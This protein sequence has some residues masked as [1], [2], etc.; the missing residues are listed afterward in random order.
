METCL[1]GVKG[2]HNNGRTL[3]TA[4]FICIYIYFLAHTIH[5]AFSTSENTLQN[6]N[7]TILTLLPMET[8]ETGFRRSM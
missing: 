8:I 7:T 2:M 1:T 6:I 3:R 5:C 4:T